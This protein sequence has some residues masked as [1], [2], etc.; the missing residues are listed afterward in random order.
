LWV[1]PDWI[2]LEDYNVKSDPSTGKVTMIE[3]KR[4]GA[5][6]YEAFEVD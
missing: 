1:E 2:S 4:F 6:I 5:I 3:N